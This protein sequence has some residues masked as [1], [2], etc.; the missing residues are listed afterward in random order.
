MTIKIRN[1]IA[2]VQLQ[3]VLDHQ[4][5]Y[6]G[7]LGAL[8][9]KDNIDI[10]LWSP[11]AQKIELLLWDS[12]DGGKSQKFQMNQQKKG[13]WTQKAC[14]LIFVSRVVLRLDM[15]LLTET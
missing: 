3:G 8:L 7:P 12:P 6:D 5:F 9:S 4:F 2:G 14:A 10:T 11:T 13:Q 1:G 15:R